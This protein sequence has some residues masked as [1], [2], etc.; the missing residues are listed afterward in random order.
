MTALP[1]DPDPT[2][3]PDLDA[4]GSVLPGS[5]PPDSGSATVGLSHKPKETPKNLGPIVIGITITLAVMIS[6][7]LILDALGRFK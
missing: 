4:G 6:V 1:P 5:T 7:F 2:N 3:D